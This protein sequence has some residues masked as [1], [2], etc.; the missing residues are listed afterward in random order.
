MDQNIIAGINNTAQPCPMSQWEY[1]I[2]P[3]DQGHKIKK[4]TY[5][6]L[7]NHPP[8]PAS[9]LS[10]LMESQTIIKDF[11][12]NIEP[13]KSV[14]DVSNIGSHMKIFYLCILVAY[15]SGHISRNH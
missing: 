11:M 3:E 6:Y 13:W 8:P 2:I 10:S 9:S 7:Y 4:L 12:P 15:N 1:K 14:L 5:M